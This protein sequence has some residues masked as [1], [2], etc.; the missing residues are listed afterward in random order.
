MNIKISDYKN[1][2]ICHINKMQRQMT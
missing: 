1:S 2:W